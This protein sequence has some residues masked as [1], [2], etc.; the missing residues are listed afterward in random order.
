MRVS[1]GGTII[2]L[3]S[4]WAERMMRPRVSVEGGGEEDGREEGKVDCRT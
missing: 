3:D 4:P 1:Q 2:E